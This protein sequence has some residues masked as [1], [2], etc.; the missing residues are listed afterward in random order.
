MCGAYGCYSCSAAWLPVERNCYWPGGVW[1][2][3]PVM[4]FRWKESAF[5]SNHVAN[6]HCD[7]P[8]YGAAIKVHR[9]VGAHAQDLG[10]PRRV[11]SPLYLQEDAICVERPREWPRGVSE[12]CKP[13]H[14]KWPVEADFLTFGQNRA[15]SFPHSSLSEAEQSAG[16]SLKVNGQIWEEY[17]SSPVSPKTLNYSFKH[18]RALFVNFLFIFFLF[19]CVIIMYL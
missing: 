2:D 9:S 13:R 11:Q 17:L 16:C 15:S 5:M 18:C 10:R 1:F 4:I 12:M 19:S 6:T 8:L 7:T 14:L 3:V